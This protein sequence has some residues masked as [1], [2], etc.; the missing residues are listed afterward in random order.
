M[1][2]MRSH[3]PPAQLYP[4]N[5]SHGSLSVGRCPPATVASITWSARS[6]K[7]LVL[8]RTARNAFVPSATP[9][10]STRTVQSR[11][12]E[13]KN[14]EAVL[15]YLLLLLDCHHPDDRAG[16]DN[17]PTRTDEL[18]WGTRQAISA[19]CDAPGSHR[20]GQCL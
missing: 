3:R 8:D 9:D 12:R 4:G 13:S 16:A 19:G 11:Y 7:S 17:K 10:T 20:C 6:A 2:F 14:Y 5:I 15:A 18:P 1:F